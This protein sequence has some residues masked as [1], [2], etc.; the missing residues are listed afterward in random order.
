MTIFRAFM[1]LLVSP[2]VLDPAFC[3]A[4][5]IVAHRGASHDAPENTLAAFELAWQ[6]GSDDKSFKMN[7]RFR[8]VGAV[9]NGR[10]TQ[11]L[12]EL[13]I[14]LTVHEKG[15]DVTQQIYTNGLLVEKANWT[16]IQR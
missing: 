5:M 6:Q 15:I 8:S 3:L 7:H 12:M 10:R 1:W 16:L 9:N 14:H 11:R 4:Q 13:D 2:L